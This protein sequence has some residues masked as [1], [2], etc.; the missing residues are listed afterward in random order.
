MK[1]NIAFILIIIILIFLDYYNVTLFIY[2]TLF[3]GVVTLPFILLKKHRKEAFSKLLI[4]SIIITTNLSFLEISEK[5]TI[6]QLEKKLLSE[7]FKNEKFQILNFKFQC[8]DL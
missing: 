1:N 2:L 5:Y 6:Y 8:H 4:I 7:N 3:L